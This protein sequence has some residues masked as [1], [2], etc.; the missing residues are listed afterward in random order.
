MD[1]E[2][3]MTS[4]AASIPTSQHGPFDS[5]QCLP[6]L[7]PSWPYLAGMLREPKTSVALSVQDFSSLLA[8]LTGQGVFPTFSK[9]LR[10][11]GLTEDLPLQARGVLQRVDLLHK[12]GA[13]VI[14]DTFYEVVALLRGA[15]LT[16]MP[17]KG[18]HLA[19]RFYAGAALRPMSDIDL[20]FTDLREGAHAHRLLHEAGYVPKE[21]SRGGD[22]WH[23]SRHLPELECPRT[24]VRVEIH[25]GLIYAPLDRRH[26][27][28]RALLENLDSA[29]YAG[30]SLPVIAPESAAVLALA[31]M[32]QRHAADEPK[33]SALLDVQT[34]L[35][36]EGSQFNWSK[37]TAVAY[38]SGLAEPV[39]TGLCA[40]QKILDLAVPVDVTEELARLVPAST[41]RGAPRKVVLDA[42]EWDALRHSTRPVARAFHMLCPSHDFVVQ[43]FP[44]KA[45]WPL[46]VLYPYRWAIQLGK[47]PSLLSSRPAT[48]NSRRK[49]HNS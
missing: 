36:K 29:E 31:H 47:V 1:F 35:Q 23:W 38:V 49:T 34:I 44:E 37:L 30:S 17:I 42:Q 41:S 43:R 40:G 8:A 28:E 16:P 20:L 7:P 33:L 12:A 9:G 10:Q 13:A 21:A 27:H 4:T 48:H 2:E 46:L 26:V 14:W 39:L 3:S 22:P 15:G 11:P 25:G 18:T 6:L 45:H 5:G 19:Q 32:F 24:K